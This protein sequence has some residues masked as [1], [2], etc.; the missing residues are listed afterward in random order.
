V[1][2]GYPT[3]FARPNIKLAHFLSR[4]VAVAKRVSVRESL[5]SYLDVT[6]YSDIDSVARFNILCSA[7]TQENHHTEKQA[8]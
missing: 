5:V 6:G 1:Q 2:I 3:D 8:A 7:A 4:R